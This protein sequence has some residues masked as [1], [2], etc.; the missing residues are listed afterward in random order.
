MTCQ[1]SYL[2][3]SYIY[4]GQREAAPREIR[5][6]RFRKSGSIRGRSKLQKSVMI[7]E[8]FAYIEKERGREENEK[9]GG[10]KTNKSGY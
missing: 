7:R 9:K 3:D 1:I 6:N 8:Q 10:N 4:R 2:R 5:V